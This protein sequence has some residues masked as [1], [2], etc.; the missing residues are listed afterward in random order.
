[1]HI[2]ILAD[3]IDNQSAGVHHYTKNLVEELLRIDQKNTYSLI[4]ER[5]NDF[6]NNTNHYIV[7]K[8]NFPG[9]GTYRKFFA[10]PGLIRKLKPDIVLEPC[11]IGPFSL[12]K[13]IK[14]AVTIHDLTPV[15]FPQF[16]IKR[17]TIVHKLLLKQVLKNAD[18]IITASE[19]NKKDI[20]KYSHTKAPIAVIPLGLKATDTNENTNQKTYSLATSAA[21][22]I[23][24]LGTIEP[25]KNL[26]IL[27]DAFLDLKK[28]QQ[29]PHKLILAGEIGWKTEKIIQNTQH[30]EIILTGYVNESEKQQLYQNASVFVYPSLY[31]GFGLPPMEA[32]SYG[33]PVIC[34]TGGALKEIYKNQAALFDPNDKEQLKKLLAR[35]LEKRPHRGL[36]NMPSFTK[37]AQKTLQALEAA[38]IR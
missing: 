21:P 20:L 24:Y 9:A 34:S 12:P 17:S 38:I 23:L 14:R 31:E 25:R 35:Y 32:M 27:I 37:T 30:P 29:I 2:C 1:M 19:N 3:T 16:H 28:D 18:L 36:R 4:H 22:Y 11:H 26:K 10:I 6:F 15:L 8:K 33:L 5:P 7:P 13:N